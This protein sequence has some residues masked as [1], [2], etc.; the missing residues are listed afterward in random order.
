MAKSLC[1]LLI[2]VIHA[3]VKNIFYVTN[4]FFKAIHENKILT[5]IMYD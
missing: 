5:N 4:M 1:C 2:K 3:V